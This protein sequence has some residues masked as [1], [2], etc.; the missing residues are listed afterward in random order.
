MKNRIFK[1]IAILCLTVCALLSCVSC[2]E[3]TPAESNLT[4]SALQTALQTTDDYVNFSETTSGSGYIYTATTSVGKY[5]VNTTANKKVSSVKI[6]IEVS[7][8][9]NMKNADELKTILNKSSSQITRSDLPVMYAALQAGNIKKA[10]GGASITGQEILNIF[11][12]QTPLQ[13]GNWTI[14]ASY[15]SNS[16]IISAVFMA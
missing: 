8:T 14:S 12:S 7:S 5:T 15:S 6:E 13:E 3:T 16:V 10:V 1:T 11:S 4:V 2:G 9:S